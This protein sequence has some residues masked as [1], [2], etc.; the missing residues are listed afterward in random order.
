TVANSIA[1]WKVRFI[2]RAPRSRPTAPWYFGDCRPSFVVVNRDMSLSPGNRNS[3]SRQGRSLEVILEILPAD[4]CECAASLVQGSALFGARRRVSGGPGL[5]G[6]SASWAA[7]RRPS[8]LVPHASPGRLFQTRCSAGHVPWEYAVW[9]NL[10]G[11]G[12]AYAQGT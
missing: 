7:L 11:R 6:C 4:S 8:A 10:A 1:R 12:S 9:N 5:A 3:S 2:S